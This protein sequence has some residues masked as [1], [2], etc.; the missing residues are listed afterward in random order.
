MHFYNNK[1]EFNYISPFVRVLIFPGRLEG[2]QVEVLELRVDADRGADL[3]A[4]RLPGP[5]RH[6]GHFQ[7]HRY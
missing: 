2:G 6:Q 7:R 5:G 1:P 4:G 3:G